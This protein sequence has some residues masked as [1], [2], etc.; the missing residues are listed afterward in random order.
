[1]FILIALGWIAYRVNWIGP[2]AT[3][4]LT[5]LLLYMVIPAVTIQAFQRTFDADQL[6][7]IGMS[8]AASLATFALNILISRL[9]FTR[10]WVPNEGRRVALRFGTV[11]SNA[12]FMGVPLTHAIL[13]D[14]GVLYAVA[15]VASYTIFNW[16]YGVSLFDQ[17]IGSAWRRVRQAVLKPGILAILVALPLFLL[18]V[19]IPS[20]FSDA[21]GYLASMNTPLSMI[22]VGLSLAEFSLRTVFGDRLVW[23]GTLVR[24]ILMPLLFVGLLVL[25]PIDP[26]ARMAILTGVSTPVGAMLVI[27][28]VRYEK[29]SVFA[30]RLLCLSTLL[31]VVTL[32]G[33]IALATMLW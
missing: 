10:R 32:P 25:V 21:L 26:V 8:F 27:F 22:V 19:R 31:S 9:L 29:D 2:T 23:I 7:N 33:M 30:T 5:N 16:T 18:S 3:K 14:D 11:F 4:G 28:T 15:Y 6:R 13:G 20:P 17:N 24:N 12:G 1:M